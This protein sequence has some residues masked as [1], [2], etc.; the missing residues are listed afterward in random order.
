M[1]ED[2]THAEVDQRKF[3]LENVLNA[4][5][6]SIPRI[7][8]NA[9]GLNGMALWIDLIILRIVVFA[10]GGPP[11]ETWSAARSL[12]LPGNV[13]LGPFV[14]LTICGDSRPLPLVKG[15]RLP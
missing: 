8:F 6:N 1:L 11:C 15:D 14:T 13:L 10:V 7:V 9:I 2:E 5:L 3:L 4:Q 12:D